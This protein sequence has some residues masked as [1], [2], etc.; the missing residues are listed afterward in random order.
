MSE[1][2]VKVG[3]SKVTLEQLLAMVDK[4]P[5]ASSNV[6]GKGKKNKEICPC[7]VKLTTKK[8]TRELIKAGTLV[9]IRDEEINGRTKSIAYKKCST[10]RYQDSDFCWKHSQTADSAVLFEKELVDCVGDSVREGVLTDDYFKDA[11][12][13]G[14]SKKLTSIGLTKKPKIAKKIDADFRKSIEAATAEMAKLK[15]MTAAFMESDDDSGADAD[16]DADSDSDVDAAVSKVDPVS[17]VVTKAIPAAAPA[18][19][20]ETSP[21]DESDDDVEGD[22]DAEEDEEDADAKEEEEDA[23]VSQPKVADST[24]DVEN[25]EDATSVDDPDA[26]SD[27]GNEGDIENA[28]NSDEE[29]EGD[30][31]EDISFETIMTKEGRSLMVDPE[32]NVY[33]PEGEGEDESYTEL[34]L[35]VRCSSEYAPI[36]HEGENYIVGETIYFRGKE[37]IRCVLTGFAYREKDDSLEF[38]GDTRSNDDG[39]YKIVKFNPKGKGGKGGKGG[40][41]GKGKKPI[42][43]V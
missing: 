14:S 11:A 2:E 30:D 39:T 35:L 13:R 21:S 3:K 22:A 6:K 4:V 16:A 29:A 23:D 33:S 37:Y 19:P 18:P 41:P 5:V 1:T 26:A 9:Y 15:A 27:D 25:A 32:K 34:G 10:T 17:A 8:K 43:K 12:P 24:S 38:S 42:K 20:T 7:A 36:Y 31:E 28:D 40:K